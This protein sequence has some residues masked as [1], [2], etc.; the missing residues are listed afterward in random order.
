MSDLAARVEISVTVHLPQARSVA[1][2]P[3]GRPPAGPASVRSPLPPARSRPY[4]GAW[5][6]AILATIAVTAGWAAAV[7]TGAHLHPTRLPHDVALFAHL[8]SLVVGFGAVIVLDAYGAGCLVRRRGPVEV[9]W[10]AAVLD[11]LIWGGLAGLAVSGAFLDPN[12]ASPLTWVKL[13]AVLA[14]GL[15]GVNAHSL[16]TAV[17]ALPATTA[18]R[19]LPIRLRWRLAATATVSQTA[20]WSAVLIGFWNN[21]PA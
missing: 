14:A 13:G 2:L 6:R 15:N 9:A 18:L 20:W 8:L 5:P 7:Y 17:A 12:L 4:G 10:F 19:D 1:V 3:S 11:P 16:R 21:Q